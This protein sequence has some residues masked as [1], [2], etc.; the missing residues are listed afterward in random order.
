MKQTVLFFCCIIF[1]HL[2]R[3]QLPRA[4]TG[5]IKRV[6]HFASKYVDARNIDIWLPDGYST[7]QQYAVLYMHDGQMLFDATTNWNKKEWGLMKSWTG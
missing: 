4:S 2:T 3:A 5:S 7:Q 6:E 1:T